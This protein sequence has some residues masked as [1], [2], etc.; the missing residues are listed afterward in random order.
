MPADHL[1]E[2]MTMLLKYAVKNNLVKKLTQL[3][4]KC[5]QKC[6]Q[7]QS[8]A[9]KSQKNV[10]LLFNFFISLMEEYKI[11]DEDPFVKTIKSVFANLMANYKELCIEIVIEK[12]NQ[13]G[14]KFI[15]S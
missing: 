13:F 10:K 12:L 8:F 14:D 15:S 2:V 11:T 3:L 6:T 4:M 7:S 5:V 9:V 1:L